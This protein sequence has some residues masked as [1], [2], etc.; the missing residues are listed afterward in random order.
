MSTPLK[1]ACSNKDLEIA[2]VLL[3]AGADPN[4]VTDVSH[5][6]RYTLHPL[7]GCSFFKELDSTYGSEQA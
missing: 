4:L 5:S 2:R 1:E 7:K 6:Y 3:E